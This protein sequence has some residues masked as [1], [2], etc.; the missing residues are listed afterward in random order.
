MKQDSGRTVLAGLVLASATIF[1]VACVSHQNAETTHTMACNDVPQNGGDH[2]VK[3]M[4]DANGCP[5]S[6]DQEEFDVEKS[7]RIVWQSV[8]PE[9]KTP[10]YEIYFDPFK[11]N[12]LK[13][14]GKGNRKSPPFK[15]C[16][17]P[18]VYKYTIVGT[19]CAGDP[20]DPRFRLR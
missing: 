5:D 4:F 8:D 17:P 14:N 10:D 11:G 3:I 12:P 18:G 9:G 16:S 19:S 7:K 20:L 1:L 13:S 6:V 2:D 15:S